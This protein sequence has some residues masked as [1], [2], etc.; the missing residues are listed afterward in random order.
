MC[1]DCPVKL[2][3]RLEGYAEGHGYWGNTSADWR[4]RTRRAIFRRMWP[5][6][7]L[8][9]DDHAELRYR[10]RQLVAKCGGDVISAM[11]RAGFVRAEVKLFA[12]YTPLDR[13]A[14]AA[15]MRQERDRTSYGWRQAQRAPIGAQ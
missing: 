11:Y 9:L 1:F 13:R 2:Q 3:C 10:V 15:I 14:E 5:T 12:D 4:T 6:Q 7:V 8:A